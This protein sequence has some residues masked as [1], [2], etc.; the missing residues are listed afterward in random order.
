MRPCD[1][2]AHALDQALKHPAAQA[3]L[4]R[5]ASAEMTVVA[6]PDFHVLEALQPLLSHLTRTGV[7]RHRVELIVAKDD[8][9]T[10][11]KLEGCVRLIESRGRRPVHW[12]RGW[13]P[14]WL[15]GDVRVHVHDPRTANWFRVP[16]DGTPVF[17]DD[18]LRETEALVL[19]GMSHDGD[20]PDLDRLLVPGLAS[21]E[22]RA[23][24]REPGN[25]DLPARVARTFGVDLAITVGKYPFARICDPDGELSISPQ[26]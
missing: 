8:R 19:V 17:L 18:A 2:A 26:S 12:P 11:E 7:R 6:E 20:A 13:V 25:S 24:C 21:P 10:A 15:Y 9:K 23:A 5:L 14:E 3:A 22:T 1:G 16:V 4:A